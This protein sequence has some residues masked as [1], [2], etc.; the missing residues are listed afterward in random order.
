MKDDPSWISVTEILQAGPGKFMKRLLKIEDLDQD[1]ISEYINRITAIFSI[2]EI[3][4]HIDEVT[5]D[6]KSVV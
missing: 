1:Q 4:L 6:R 2:K 3:D 5:G